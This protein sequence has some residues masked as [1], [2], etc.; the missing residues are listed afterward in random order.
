MASTEEQ[1][2]YA[3]QSAM[4][5]PGRYASLF[6][7]APTDEP[8][9]A[10]WVRNVVFHE[11]YAAQAGLDLPA[12]A[13]AEPATSDAAVRFLEPMLGRILARDDRPL[14]AERP[15][16]RCFIGTCRDYA[17][18]FCALLRHQGRPARARCG[19]AF[20]FEP[21]GRIG[22]DHWVTEV[23]DAVQAR[24]R[25]V[26]SEI[27]PALPQHQAITVDPFDI[28]RDQFQVA[29]K[30]WQGFRAGAAGQYGIYGLGS[31]GDWFLAA[32]V[33]RDLAALNKHETSCF[34]YWGPTTVMCMTETVTADQRD[35]V[36][37]LAAVT[38]E[39]PVDFAALRRAYAERRELRVTDPVKSWPKGVETDA[40]LGL[41]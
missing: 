24:W 34:D 23:W 17:L 30:A 5:D 40:R 38:A 12:E 32:S 14:D 21:E 16:D 15:K 41:G 13:V 1:S 6:D 4:S 19:F 7:A 10:H 37:G 2:F 35:L 29:G 22:Y 11:A 39:N 9:L 3:T 26:D 25:L 33:I 31:Q 20:Y 18:L 36:D 28:P 27:D 8:D